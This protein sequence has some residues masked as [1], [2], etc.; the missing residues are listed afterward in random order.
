MEE[1]NESYCDDSGCDTYIYDSVTD[2]DRKWLGNK[3]SEMIFEFHQKIGLNPRWF[4]VFSMEEVN[5]NNY[6]KRLE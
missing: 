3:L 1:L 6:E 2:E 5:L 4:K